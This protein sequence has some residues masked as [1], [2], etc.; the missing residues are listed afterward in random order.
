MRTARSRVLIVGLKGNRQGTEMAVD[1][2]VRAVN[3]RVSFDYLLHEE[4]A[5]DGCRLPGNRAFMI[6]RKGHNPLRYR[7][8]LN[9]LFDDHSGEWSAVWLNTGNLANIDSLV[10]AKRYEVPRR[11]LHAHSDTWLGG[12]RQVA[13]TKANAR[14]ALSLT[15]DRWACSEGAGKLFF[16]DSPFTLVPNA[17]PFER[18]AYSEE[19]RSAIREKLGLEGRFVLGSVGALV[20]RKNHKFLVRILP[21]IV[22]RVPEACLL[23]VGEGTEEERLVGLAGDLGVVD[24]LI[25]AGGQD[26]VPAFLSAMDAFAFPSLH[27]G[28]GLALIEAQANGLPVVA[29]SACTRDVA[30]TDNILFLDLEDEGSWIDGLCAADRANVNLN[31]RAGLFDLSQE[32][33]FLCDL[34]T[35]GVAC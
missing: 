6:P 27:E 35:N 10:M 17:V 15:T 18:Y 30:I 8:E 22:A 24:R 32:G 31:E 33:D 34:F 4:P 23:I 25:L 13:M 26:D 11:I 28:L 12:A 19:D 9:K 16:G 5:F 21:K 29:S 3:G 2:F 1:N 7:H 20:P 14:R